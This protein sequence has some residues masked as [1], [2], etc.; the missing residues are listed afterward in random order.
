MKCSQMFY[1]M[2]QDNNR[3]HTHKTLLQYDQLRCNKSSK[4][5]TQ[6]D[7]CDKVM[8]TIHIIKKHHSILF[9]HT[10]YRAIYSCSEDFFLLIF[11][12]FFSFIL[13]HYAPITVEEIDHTNESNIKSVINNI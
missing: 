2:Y 12:V 4:D 6:T 13:N 9:H 11:L 8:F 1:E 10:F 7:L 3:S 5:M